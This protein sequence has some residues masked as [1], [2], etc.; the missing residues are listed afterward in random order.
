MMEIAKLVTTAVATTCLA[1]AAH[2]SVSGGSTTTATT[3]FQFL[4]PPP[5]QVGQDNQDD[6]NTL[7]AFNEKQN[8][9]L[10]SDLVVDDAGGGVPGIIP[11]GTRVASH[12]VFFDPAG[13]INLVSI[14]GSVQFDQDI[15]G[16]VTTRDNLIA[17]DFLGAVGTS[18]NSPSARGLEPPDDS[19][20]IS[21]AR[22][23]MTTL[24]ASSPGDYFR[25]ITVVPAPG[26][27]TV[28]AAGAGLLLRRR[29]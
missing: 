7:F 4:D 16:L 26:T 21:G 9:L 8:F 3:D 22:E 2:A 19:A 29:R 18:Y 12:Y 5:L 13:V 11:A 20:T 25:V 28:L 6:S 10:T 24:V 27:A 1:A 15:L 23:I 17:S 14:S